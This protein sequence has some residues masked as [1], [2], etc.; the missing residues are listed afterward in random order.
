VG[1]EMRKH[2]IAVKIISQQIKK[3]NRDRK[4]PS[5]I[6]KNSYFFAKISKNLLQNNKK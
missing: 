1:K 5:K 3:V 4:I 6:A 2:N